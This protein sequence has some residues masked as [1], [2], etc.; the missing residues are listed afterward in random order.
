MF[1]A[2]TDAELTAEQ[3][4]HNNEIMIRQQGARSNE[5]SNG[6]SEVLTLLSDLSIV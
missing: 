3:R 6:L 5:L 4:A 1:I 2:P